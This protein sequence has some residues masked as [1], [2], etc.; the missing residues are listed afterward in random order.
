MPTIRF[1]PPHVLSLMP[2]LFRILA[3][4]TRRPRVLST[5]VEGSAAA[6][7]DERRSLGPSALGTKVRQALRCWCACLRPGTRVLRPS[8]V[9]LGPRLHLGRGAILD[10]RAGLIEIAAGAWIGSRVVVLTGDPDLAG[11]HSVAGTRHVRIGPDA[12]VGPGAILLPGVS[13]GAGSVVAAGAVVTHPVLAHAIVAGIPARVIGH[14]VPG[15]N[16]L[17]FDPTRP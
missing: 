6:A 11:E 13:V 8:G 15:T 17:E 12:D 2:S 7:E 14:R 5:L 9:V 16:C 10:A 4:H 1:G 3:R